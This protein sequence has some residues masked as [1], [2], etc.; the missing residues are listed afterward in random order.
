MLRNILSNSGA[1]SMLGGPDAANAV[2][3]NRL[4]VDRIWAR[5]TREEASNDDQFE[6]WPDEMVESETGDDS[7]LDAAVT[8]M[9]ASEERGVEEV[10]AGNQ[11]PNLLSRMLN[12]DAGGKGC[13]RDGLMGLIAPERP[14]DPRAR[15]KQK[16]QSLRKQRTTMREE[17]V[18]RDERGNRIPGAR[19]I[20]M[21]DI[22]SGAVPRRLLQGVDRN[23]TKQQIRKNLLALRRT[24][25]AANP[26]AT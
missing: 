21:E 19:N 17:D 2:K 10:V 23:L 22:Q 24:P 8:P 14:A 4:E 1:A 13:N 26:T 12:P 15:L 9:P 16:M 3:H 20:T 18:M 6:I 7:D 5:M 25:P 11:G